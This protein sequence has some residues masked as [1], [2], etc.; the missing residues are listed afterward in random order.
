MTL[1]K[2]VYD[3]RCVQ[4]HGSTGKG[5]GAAAALLNVRPRDFTSGK[6]K[7]RST[8]SGS[9]PTDEDLSATIQNGLH[10][11]AM[12]DWKPFIGG[13]SLK[14]VIAYIKSFSPRFENEKPKPV[15]IGP[16][17]PSS[18][19]TVAVGKR[20]FEKLQCA[21]CHGTDGAGAEVVAT[22]LKDEWGRE[23]QATNLTEPWNFR[24]GATARDVYLRFR[25]GVD[26][27]PMPSY[28]GTASESEMWSL[29]NYVLSIKRKAAWEMNERELKGFYTT[30]D[31][32]NKDNP[33]QRGKYL[34]ETLGC[35]FCHSPLNADGSIDESKKYAGGQTWRLTPYGDFVSYNLTSDKETGL[36]GWT[37][38]EFKKFITTGVRRNG[39]RMLPFPMPWSGYAGMKDDDLN[40]IT[41]YLR[42][43]PA[44]YNKI[45]DPKSPNIFSYL[46]GKFQM[47]I[48][49][50]DLPFFTYPGNAGTAKEM[51]P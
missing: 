10:G 23:T 35:G 32:R 3:A 11:T 25:T 4:C 5:D 2:A 22:E 49:K 17:V 45:P 50:K 15:N 33:L 36:G 29:A 28:K 27:T 41:A 34:V 13:D 1:G 6:Y 51:K 40:A 44:V 39:T 12:P 18:P 19:A 7:F 43:L 24:G 16:A 26:G 30:L 46:W 37:D 20:V 42:T 8:E 31:K 48:L 47:L 9:I 38:A 21:K 14:A